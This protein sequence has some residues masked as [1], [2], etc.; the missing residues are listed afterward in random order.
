MA[1]KYHSTDNGNC[2]VYYTCG[3]HL[4]CHQLGTRWG[5]EP[6]EPTPFEFLVC[7]RDG[8]PSHK[9]KPLTPV[10]QTRGDETTDYELR[11][12]LAREAS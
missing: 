4:Y 11:T 2:R 7:S 5:L 9:T 3:R 12:W 6:A 10:E 1:F 8:E